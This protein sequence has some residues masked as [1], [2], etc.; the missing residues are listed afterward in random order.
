MQEVL[1]A[2]RL[3]IR[4]MNIRAD[5]STLAQFLTDEKTTFGITLENFPLYIR[6]IYA[7]YSSSEAIQAADCSALAKDL[8]ERR[9]RI[10]VDS[11][12]ERGIDLMPFH[13]AM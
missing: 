1:L 9:A 6:Q 4:W 8:L 12:R 3:E 7:R 5:G 10:K 11:P 13:Q 2:T